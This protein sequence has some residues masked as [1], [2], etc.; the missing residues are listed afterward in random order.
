MLTVPVLPTSHTFL[1]CAFG[2]CHVLLSGDLWNL[3]PHVSCQIT[4]WWRENW[5]SLFSRLLVYSLSNTFAAHL[6]ADGL[7]EK[8]FY[9][10]CSLLETIRSLFPVFAIKVTH[11]C[12]NE[13]QLERYVSILE[14]IP[15]WHTVELEESTEKVFESTNCSIFGV[16][17]NLAS[18]AKVTSTLLVE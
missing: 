17:H 6:R 7:S 10:C 8:H 3:G 5:C 12:E 13:A 4:S 18:V 9:Q 1:L 11:C 2:I 15:G 16:E 14:L